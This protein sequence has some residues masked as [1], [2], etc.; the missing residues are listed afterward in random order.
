MT[1]DILHHIAD[2]LDA[3]EAVRLAEPGDDEHAAWEVLSDSGGSL[4]LALGLETHALWSEVAAALRAHAAALAPGLPEGWDWDENGPGAYAASA[5]G[6][7]QVEG[8]RFWIEDG[9]DIA[10]APV[11]VVRAVLARAGVAP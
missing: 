10:L 4:G 2:V 11:D 3:I 6:Y 9:Q 5:N 8:G 1:P 7:V